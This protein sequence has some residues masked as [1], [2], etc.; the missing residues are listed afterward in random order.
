M[1]KKCSKK[2]AVMNEMQLI[3]HSLYYYHHVC[4]GL[5]MTAVPCKS[6][7]GTRKS[8]EVSCSYR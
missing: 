4:Y 6:L 2:Q 7:S 1:N 8:E 5:M 3:R